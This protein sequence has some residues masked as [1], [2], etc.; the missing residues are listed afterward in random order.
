[1]IATAA[2]AAGAIA[3]GLVGTGTTYA[4]WNDT[5]VVPGQLDSGT[6]SLTIDDVT[7]YPISGLD[8]TKLLPGRSVG[9]STP[10]TVKNTGVVPLT[11]TPGPVNIGDP[12]GTLASQLIVA[13]HQ[14]ASCT[15]TPVGTT[16][17]SFS[18][19]AL[20][21]NQ[22]ATIC[23]EVQLKPTAPANVQGNTATFSVLLNGVQVAS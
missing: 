13:I 7:S 3:V 21:P 6:A 8:L 10:L 4:L 16:A 12:S 23:V 2:L 1:M 22:T 20:Q 15:L 9:T 17:T 5:Q 14:T 11:V 19:F 18:S